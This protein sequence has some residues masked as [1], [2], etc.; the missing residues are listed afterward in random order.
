MGRP[1][2]K[3][4]V[5]RE[6]LQDADRG[7]RLHKAMAEAGVGSRRACERLIDDRR[8]AVNGLVIDFKPVWVDPEADRI[9]VDGRPIQ[10]TSRPGHTYVMLNKSRGVICT[11]SDPYHR[12]TVLDM[13]PHSDRLFCVGRLDAE[14]TGLVL[15]TDDG[16]LA[17]RLTHPRYEI[18]KTY[19]VAITGSLSDDDITQLTEGIYLADKSGKTAKAHAAEVKVGAR[20]REKTRLTITLREG[21]NREIRRMLA[22]LGHKVNRLKRVA[23][24]PLRLKGVAAGQWRALTRT[25]VNALRDAA[26]AKPKSPR[27][28]SPRPGKKKQR[29]PRRK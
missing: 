15:M 23:I 18:A 27:G 22:R 5:R 21:R 2:Q 6:D 24:G 26:Y 25:E 28:K 16:A 1:R 10:S 8:V 7:V 17:Q 3:I 20:D 29:S 12:K 9:S 19:Q 4:T 13:I 11:S 14:S